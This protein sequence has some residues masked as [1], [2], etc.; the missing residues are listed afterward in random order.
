MLSGPM[1][2]TIRPLQPVVY[3][4]GFVKYNI[5]RASIEHNANISELLADVDLGTGA[6]V[7]AV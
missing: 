5:P 1:A 2:L 4:R 7:V 3:P 6:P